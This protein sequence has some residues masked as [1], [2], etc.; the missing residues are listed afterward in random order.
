MIKTGKT[1][2]W[3]FGKIFRQRAEQLLL[4]VSIGTFLVREREH[5]PGDLTL[6]IRDEDR[7]QHYRIKFDLN[8][9]S[10]T[11]DDEMFFSDLNLL[12]QVSRF[13][14]RS[15]I[16]KDV[17]LFQHYESDADGL[18]CRLEKALDERQ[19][20]VDSTRLQKSVTANIDC[21]ELHIG[22]LVGSGEFAGKKESEY[23][24]D[25]RYRFDCRGVRGN[26][27]ED[28]CCN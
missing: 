8:N 23:M 24:L 25:N 22:K 2:S 7:I 11:V 6:S 9:R 19:D 1:P 4:N 14:F 12:V 16:N 3:N 18:C 13:S 21:Q 10:Y 20:A 26:L 27:S 17:F 5:F 15:Y 28:T